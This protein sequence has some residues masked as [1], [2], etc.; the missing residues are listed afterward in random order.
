MPSYEIGSSLHYIPTP[1]ENV[2]PSHYCV[3]GIEDVISISNYLI[4]TPYL[5]VINSDRDITAPIKGVPLATDNILFSNDQIFET[6]VEIAIP[7]YCILI[8]I[9]EVIPSC[10]GIGLPVD[11]VQ[12]PY[13]LIAAPFEKVLYARNQVVV[14]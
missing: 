7:K 2:I 12:F 14:P 4:P 1:V 6:F 10:E 11:G 8:S 5:H 3:I 9:D 13:D